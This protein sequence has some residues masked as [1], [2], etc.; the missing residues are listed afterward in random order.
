M[1]LFQ[2]SVL[3]KH[4]NHLDESKVVSAYSKFQENYNPQKV[5]QIIQLNSFYDHDFKTQ[6]TELTKQKITL[7]QHQQ[8][9]WQDYFTTYNPKSPK[10]RMKSM[11]WFMSCMD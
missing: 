6:I 4:L 8:D 3:N 5:D 1:A 2:K 7:S 11:Q 10:P 9:E